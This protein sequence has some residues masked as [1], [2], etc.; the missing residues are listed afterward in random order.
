MVDKNGNPITKP[1]RGFTYF[2]GYTP[3]QIK[4]LENLI[5]GWKQKYPNINWK[6]DYNNLFPGM[7]QTEIIT[8]SNA[9]NLI[10]GVYSHCSTTKE[11]LDLLPQK[12]L[13]DMLKRVLDQ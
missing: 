9:E 11:K 8:S 2:Q 4:A 10:P 12:E 5:I 3:E 6:F 7:G 13:I 1:Y